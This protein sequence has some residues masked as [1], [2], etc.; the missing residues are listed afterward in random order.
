M[1]FVLADELK[2]SPFNLSLSLRLFFFFT[3]F[4]SLGG[5]CYPPTPAHRF[6]THTHTL[7][8]SLLHSPSPWP[9]SGRWTLQPCS[10]WGGCTLFTHA[11]THHSLWDRAHSP[12]DQIPLFYNQQGAAK[13]LHAF[14]CRSVSSRDCL[15]GWGRAI[16][17]RQ[18]WER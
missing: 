18:N 9:D 5:G 6:H 16:Q 2:R 17:V 13:A 1:I 10:V 15:A 3:L 14:G 11:D 4:S 8:E 12:L 7:T